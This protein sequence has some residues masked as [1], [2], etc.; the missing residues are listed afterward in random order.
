MF[1]QI[2]FGLEPLLSLC[3]ELRE[4]SELSEECRNIDDWLTPSNYGHQHRD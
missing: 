1:Q 4:Q 2:V 3:V